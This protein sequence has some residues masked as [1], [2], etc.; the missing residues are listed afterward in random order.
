MP[1]PIKPAPRTA[2]LLHTKIHCNHWQ[3]A[4]MLCAFDWFVLSADRA[5][6]LTDHPI[7]NQL[8][9]RAAINWNGHVRLTDCCTGERS[10]SS[11]IGR[12]QNRSNAHNT[13]IHTHTCTHTY[14]TP[15]CLRFHPR[16]STIGDVH[17][18]SGRFVSGTL[19]HCH[20]RHCSHCPCSSDSSRLCRLPAA[21]TVNATY[22]LH[23][24]PVF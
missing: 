3:P 22:C 4:Q 17:L 5:A 16:R 2:R 12:S 24:D 9:D 23:H 19:F 1:A 20:S 7:A 13:Y 18:P 11:A 10:T 15:T 6:L 21:S 8:V 14:R